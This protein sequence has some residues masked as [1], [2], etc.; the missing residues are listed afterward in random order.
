MT[1][2]IPE[3]ILRGVGD[4]AISSVSLDW[5]VAAFHAALRGDLDQIESSFAKPGSRIRSEIIEMLE[6]ET[7]DAELAAAVRARINGAAELAEERD[8]VVHGYVWLGPTTSGSSGVMSRHARSK[9]EQEFDRTLTTRTGQTSGGLGHGL[10]TN[11]GPCHHREGSRVGRRDQRTS[12]MAEH[13]R[14]ASRI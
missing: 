2:G 10:R 5:Q 12:S 1:I 14:S 6:S 8:Q 3:P 9:H 7:L 4:V 11:A 13:R